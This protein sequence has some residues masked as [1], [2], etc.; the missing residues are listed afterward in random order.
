MHEECLVGDGRIRGVDLYHGL[1]ENPCARVGPSHDAKLPANTLEGSHAEPYLLCSF[2]QWEV[3]HRLN[4]VSADDDLG[5][6][7][8]VLAS[9]SAGVDGYL[10]FCG[11]CLWNCE[12]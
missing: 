9:L 11:H 4:D 8:L 3:E 7:G 2:G 5:A 6:V 10:G 1:E 12:T